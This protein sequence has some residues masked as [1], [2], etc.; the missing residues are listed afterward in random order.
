MLR[1]CLRGTF[2]R[3][4]VWAQ[5]TVVHIPCRLVVCICNHGSMH[6][7]VCEFMCV[8]DR[9]SVR[10]KKNPI[11]ILEPQLW[12][13]W[14]ERKKPLMILET[15]RKRRWRRRWRW[16]RMSREGKKGAESL[17]PLRRFLHNAVF[18][19]S[20]KNRSDPFSNNKRG[21]GAVYRSD[22]WVEVTPTS[23]G[24]TCF[25]SPLHIYFNLQWSILWP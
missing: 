23:A 14:N 5:I 17:N 8:S 24:F 13:G 22:D 3:A 15:E 16:R 9:L 12:C 11:K 21:V 4:C 18:W 10:E 1:H 19:F 6:M 20:I 2:T 25:I 7:C